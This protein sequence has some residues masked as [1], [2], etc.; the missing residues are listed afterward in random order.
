MDDRPQWFTA[1]R[2]GF[3]AGLP[4]SWQGWLVLGV[5]IAI[6]VAASVLLDGR[7]LAQGAI[8]VPATVALVIILAR[9]TRGGWR[10]RWGQKDWVQL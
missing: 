9:T 2:Y 6:V 8:V 10:W 5:Y 3:G 1:K 7:R 4:I